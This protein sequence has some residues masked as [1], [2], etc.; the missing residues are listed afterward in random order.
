MNTVG[1]DF[2]VH[3]TAGGVAVVPAAAVAVAAG[4]VTVPDTVGA[5]FRRAAPTALTLLPICLLLGV[6]AGHSNWSVFEVLLFSALGFSGSGQFA[7]L[8]LA[9]QGQSLLVM[10]ALTASINSRYIPM[11]LTTADRLPRSALRR[12]FVAHIL[13]DEAFAIERAG[14]S[15]RSVLV[16][17][18]T[19]YGTW[20]LAT[21]V[22]ALLARQV[23][24]DLGTAVNLG[25][26]A[27]VVLFVL[28]FSQL[29][30]RVP[31]I[32]ASWRRRLIEVGL[33]VLVAL[34]LLAVL[35]PAW[36]WLPS[37]AFSSWRVWEAER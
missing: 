16:V 19:I 26:P 25:F 2:A 24:T 3:K 1:Q 34:G 18:A 4:A 28:S 8:P 31:Q 36:F 12:G 5:A 9:E 35:G 29:K 17:R 15:R 20:V 11:A 32:G 10:L 13:G 33:C 30:V 22:G 6:L 27:S 7:L 14:D 21:V 37:I 23:P